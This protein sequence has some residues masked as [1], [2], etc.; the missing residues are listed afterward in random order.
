MLVWLLDNSG[1]IRIWDT[2]QAEHIL[3]YEYQPISGVIK[4]IVWS[5]DSKRIAV[6]GE[7]REKC[8]P[9]KRTTFYI[10]SI[11]R[12]GHVFLWD[13]GSSVGDITG[14]SKPI[15]SIDY[16]QVRP[17]RVATGGED[18]IACWYEGPPFRYKNA[19]HD[20]QRFVNVVRFSP[21]G[22]RLLTGGADGKV[23]HYI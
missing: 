5:P 12:F 4:D 23:C 8:V 6:C 2:T 11:F 18:R 19:F 1:K 21:D 22:E 9:V 20:H 17:F 15:N 7:G 13:S 10:V 3:K 14:H 16:R